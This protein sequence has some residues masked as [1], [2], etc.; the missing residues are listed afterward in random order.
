MVIQET[1]SLQRPVGPP[2]YRGSQKAGQNLIRRRRKNQVIKKGRKKNKTNKLNLTKDFKSVLL[3]IKG[4][5]YVQ[6]FM[7]QFN[8]DARGNE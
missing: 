6:V 4:Q 5:N 1:P 3:D 8:L 2:K 7:P